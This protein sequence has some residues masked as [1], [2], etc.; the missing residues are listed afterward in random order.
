VT[1]FATT[2][3]LADVVLDAGPP[4]ALPVATATRRLRLLGAAQDGRRPEGDAGEPVAGELALCEAGGCVTCRIGWDSVCSGS[5]GE[6]SIQALAGLAALHGRA[7]GAPARLGLE[8]AS[9]TAGVL[10]SQGLLAARLGRLR[11]ARATRAETSALAAALLYATHHVAVATGGPGSS[12]LGEPTGWGPP[13]ATA[14]DHW[15]ELEVLS[16]EAW[17]RFWGALGAAGAPLADGW[18][19][20]ARR[21][22]LGRCALPAALHRATRTRTVDELRGVAANTGVALCVVR[23]YP[24]VLRSPAWRDPPWTIEPGPPGVGRPSTARAP[25]ALP[26]AGLRVVELT[27][28]LQGPLAGLLLGMLGA[29]VVKIEPPGGDPGRTA[30]R[31]PYQAAYAAYNRGKRAVEL[32]YTRAA[33]RGELRELAADADV[34]IHNARP[35][36]AERVGFDAASLARVNDAMVHVTAAGWGAGDSAPSEIAGDFL[37]QAHAGCGHGLAPPGRP[38]FPSRVTLLDVMGGLIACEGALAGLLA[39]ERTGA[40]ARVRTSLLA[41]AMTLQRHVLDALARGRET[42]RTLGRPSWGALHQPIATRAGHLMVDAEDDASRARL[43][44]ACG[45]PRDADCAAVADRLG[46]GEAAAWEEALT[47]QGVPAARVR[48][49]LTGL[50]D[51]V[52]VAPLLEPLDAGGWAPAAPWGF[53]P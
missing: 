20:F 5:G 8:V 35:G 24:E 52:R 51:D 44:A 50:P 4:G 47:A 42:G 25:Y 34:F 43:V 13:F 28:R 48:E 30:P 12:E 19:S 33:G 14:D 53:A 10:A 37:V 26:L 23:S 15:I 6:A 32:D 21:Y 40:G 11:G 49:D 41:A 29:E 1:P 18:S 27:T 16:F 9:V 38:P 7:T 31:G 39:R 17:A 2:G 45:L 36:R 22:V 46:S 3:P